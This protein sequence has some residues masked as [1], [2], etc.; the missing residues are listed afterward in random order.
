MNPVVFLIIIIA[1]SWIHPPLNGQDACAELFILGDENAELEYTILDKKG[2]EISTVY[3]KVILVEETRL[4]TIFHFE[5]TLTDK[6]S[7][8]GPLIET[9]AMRCYKDTLFIS[10][11]SMLPAGTLE[12]YRNMQIE[13]SGND[14]P[15]PRSVKES[16]TLPNATIQ[17][18]VS[19]GGMR[20]LGIK[21]TTGERRVESK[22]KVT[23]SA[24]DFECFKIS[25]TTEVKVGFITTKTKTNSW[26]APGVG[27][28]KQET[29]DK[30]GRLNNRKEL[31]KILN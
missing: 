3:N 31:L 26:F 16:E 17:V 10:M 29:F 22:E 14:L 19:S 27:L 4:G 5:S 13:I 20:M 11:K 6:K 2:K 8:N 28:V 18:E 21:A 12:S 23:T 1:L 24:G 15:Y 7:P 9:Y 30:K 25:E